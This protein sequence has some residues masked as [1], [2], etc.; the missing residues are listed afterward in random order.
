MSSI[1]RVNDTG[2]PT[3]ELIEREDL[4]ESTGHRYHLIR[5]CFVN[6][7]NRRVFSIEFME[8]HTKEEL[9]R[10]IDAPATDDWVFHFNEPPGDSVRRIL[11][12]DFE[13]WPSAQ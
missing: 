6:R 1:F 2:V 5:W 12:E 3:S 9:Q 4:L 10:L 8:K 7:R 13:K 11:I